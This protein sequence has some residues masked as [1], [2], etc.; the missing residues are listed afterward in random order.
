MPP[1]RV[2]PDAFLLNGGLDVMTPPFELKS[3]FARLAQNFECSIFGGY[4]RIAGYERIDGRAS[5]SDAQY[6]ILPVTLVTGG[7]VGNTLTGATS[8]AT[9]VIIAITTT[10]FVLTRTV[11]VFQAEN[12]NV[13]AGTIAVSTAPATL[14]AAQSPLLHAQYNNLAADAY[15]A[16][17]GAVPGSG[18]IL[19]VFYYNDV[20]FA[21]RNNAGGT[22][23]ALYKSSPAGW[24]AVPLGRELNFTSGGTFVLVEGQTVTGATSG[25]TAVITRVALETG[26]FA[27]GTAAGHIT[28]GSQTG[29]FV[30]EN[31]NVGANLNVASIAGNGSAITQLPDGRYEFILYNFTGGLSTKRVYG[32]DGVNRAFEFDGTSFVPINTGMVIDKPSHIEG[33]LY[34]LFLSFFGS[35]QHSAPGFP[36]QWSAVVGAGE[37]AMGEAV[38]GFASQSAS[39][40][41][42]ALAIFTV[43]KL[44]ML[45]GTGAADWNLLPYRDEIGAFPYTMQ[46]L[47]QTMFLDLQGVTDLVTT[48]RFGNFVYAVLSNRVKSIITSWRS[49]AIA[50]SVSRDLS[51]YRLFFTNNFALYFTVVAGKVIGVMPCLYS[52][53]VRCA[54]S[55]RT[56]A[57]VERNFFG[58]DNGFVFEMDKGTSFDGEP[59]EAFFNLAYNFS[60]GVRLIKRYRGGALEI[61]GPGYASFNFGYA[62][63]YSLPEIIQPT[64]ERIT[65]NFSAVFWDQFVWDAFFWDGVTLGPS[66]IEIDGA[67]ENIS[68]AVRCVSDFYQPFTISAAVIN[69]SPRRQ[70]R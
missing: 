47:A 4:R 65:S 11:G 60:G 7:A 45:Y 55:G 26:T 40:T 3:G 41:A 24:I 62:L 15:R 54:W 66:T 46:N 25:A 6:S 18:K 69:Y 12:L 5:P 57:G 32:C 58:S 48:Q 20:L 30:A 53:T 38:T 68:L 43:G 52:H 2:I 37:L 36:F 67:A 70:M 22:A 49:A 44:S 27:A 63:G 35:V 61:S 64:T 28:F 19:G 9:G 51:Q 33:H 31:L 59:I 23:A 21:F 34:H 1:V 29:T 10:S 50:S 8:G 13:G 56:L 17:I 14:N 39:S 16:L 42:G